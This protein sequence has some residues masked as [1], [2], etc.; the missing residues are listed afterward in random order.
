[1]VDLDEV[2]AAVHDAENALE[3]IA[4]ASTV[5]DQPRSRV[6]GRMASS[7]PPDLLAALY[8]G[9]VGYTE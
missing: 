8:G 6:G 2:V 4:D 3:R 9:R 7:S 1:M 5:P